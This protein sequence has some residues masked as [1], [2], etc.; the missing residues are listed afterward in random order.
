MDKIAPIFRPF[1]DTTKNLDYVRTRLGWARVTDL[2]YEEQIR[3]LQ[4]PENM[5]CALAGDFFDRAEGRTTREAAANALE[6]MR[7]FLLQLPPALAEYATTAL[8]VYAKLDD[9]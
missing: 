4:G 5:T 7:P 2:P 8:E 9:L 6:T 1:L 3:F